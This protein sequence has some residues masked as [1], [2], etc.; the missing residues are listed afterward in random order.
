MKSRFILYR[1]QRGGMFYLEDTHT[2]KQESLGTK[3]RA[4]AT[5]LLHA[6]NESIRCQRSVKT[7]HEGS[8]ENQP[9]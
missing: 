1:R 3:I 5:T 2:R 7:S 4:E 6:R 9:L 8:N